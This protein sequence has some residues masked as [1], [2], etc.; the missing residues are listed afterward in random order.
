MMPIRFSMRRIALLLG[1][2]AISAAGARP[3]AAPVGVGGEPMRVPQQ[4]AKSFGEL[5]IWSDGG[6]IYVAERGQQARELQ[7]GD[8]AEAR[9]LRELLERDGATADRPRILPDRMILVGGGGTGFH[10]VPADKSATP[11]KNGAAA[12]PDRAAIPADPP[13]RTGAPPQT[14]VRGT[15]QKG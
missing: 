15:G 12:T 1:I 6:R 3:D 13:G 2:G 4:S 14:Q 9:H 10:G 5:L 7:L 8:T 11:D